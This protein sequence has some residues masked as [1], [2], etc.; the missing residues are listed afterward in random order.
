MELSQ[1]QGFVFPLKTRRI[2]GQVGTDRLTF[3]GTQLT[4]MIRIVIVAIDGVFMAG[5]SEIKLI[6]CKD[7]VQIQ[8][9]DNAPYIEVM[10]NDSY[11]VLVE[12]YYFKF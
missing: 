1:G 4:N 10:N 11:N 8:D 2:Q 9:D 3:P 6:G 7:T 5:F 12:I